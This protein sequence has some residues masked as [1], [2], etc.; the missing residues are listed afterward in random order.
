[1]KNF[2]PPHSLV[3][4]ADPETKK[5]NETGKYSVTEDKTDHFA[6]ISTKVIQCL[7]R[8]KER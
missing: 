7:G 6:E 3:S 1:M 5:K 4:F 2:L 8:V